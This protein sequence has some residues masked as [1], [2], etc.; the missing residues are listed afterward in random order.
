M[1]GFYDL[2]RNYEILIYKYKCCLNL[3]HRYY[4]GGARKAVPKMHMEKLA[5]KNNPENSE[6]NLWVRLIQVEN[7]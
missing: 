7:T 6:S 3:K 1:Q 4:V 5:C 2:L